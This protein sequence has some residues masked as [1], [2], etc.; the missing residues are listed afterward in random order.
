MS[1]QDERRCID[2]GAAITDEARKLNPSELWCVEHEEARRERITN[3][4]ADIRGFFTDDDPVKLGS[5]PPSGAD[6]YLPP[7]G[8]KALDAAEIRIKSQPSTTKGTDQ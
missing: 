5:P 6:F 3:S 7:R 8:S 1:L 4:F 2:C